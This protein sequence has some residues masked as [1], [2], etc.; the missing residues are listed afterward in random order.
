MNINKSTATTKTKYNLYR[1]D[2]D[3]PD[4]A[5]NS[6]RIRRSRNTEN[7]EHTTHQ[8]KM[9]EWLLTD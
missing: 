4:M 5:R 9:N 1:A 3:G 7:S 8:S 6:T 2:R